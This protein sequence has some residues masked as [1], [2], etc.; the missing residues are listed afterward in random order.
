METCS[1][2]IAGAATHED[3]DS[4]V[5]AG[6]CSLSPL[7]AVGF[8][9]VF[10]LLFGPALSAQTKPVTPELPSAAAVYEIGR[11]HV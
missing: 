1:C 11:A 7:V 5:L 3:V 6:G 8:T 2:R 4:S 10:G 9:I